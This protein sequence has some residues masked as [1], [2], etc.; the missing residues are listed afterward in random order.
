MTV[1]GFRSD[2]FFTNVYVTTA[3]NP[4]TWTSN[5]DVPGVSA[6]NAV[7]VKTGAVTVRNVAGS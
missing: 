6:A 2:T 7:G 5:V 1:R 3:V 4:G